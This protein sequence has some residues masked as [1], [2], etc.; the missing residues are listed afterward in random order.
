MLG[1]RR[2][3]WRGSPGALDRTCDRFV[4][5]L[6]T[7]RAAKLLEVPPSQ[8]W[9]LHGRAQISTLRVR[10][11]FVKERYGQV[12]H[13]RLLEHAGERLRQV[14]TVADPS[15]GW[16]SFDLFIELCVL[17]DRLFGR[18]VALQVVE[19]VPEEARAALGPGN[20]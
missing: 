3:P 7:I 12:G 10:E 18:G 5:S 1:A 17:I 4:L 16:I 14:L 13:E 20:W 8:S 19:E 6:S 11:A 9:A 2:R 15:D